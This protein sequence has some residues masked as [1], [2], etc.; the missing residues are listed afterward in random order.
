MLW[1]RLPCLECLIYH[2]TFIIRNH[3]IIMFSTKNIV[4]TVFVRVFVFVCLC[5]DPCH[6]HMIIFQKNFGSIIYGLK[7]NLVEIGRMSRLSTHRRKIRG[8]SDQ[9]YNFCRI[10]D[11]FL[12]SFAR[13]T[14]CTVTRQPWVLSPQA[15]LKDMLII[16]FIYW[17]WWELRK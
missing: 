2:F 17:G 12:L 16:S 8:N 7:H 11:V 10:S 1:S 4:Y 13:L 6:H 14:F 5:L 15:C 9:I 3:N